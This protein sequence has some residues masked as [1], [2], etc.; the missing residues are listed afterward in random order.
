MVE[1]PSKK[2]S[3]LPVVAGEIRSDQRL[4]DGEA[5]RQEKQR[6]FGAKTLWISN[7]MIPSALV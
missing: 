3:A 2:P 1:T 4:K 5:L 6:G 7:L